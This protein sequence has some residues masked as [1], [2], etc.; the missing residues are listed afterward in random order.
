MN[1]LINYIINELENI[2]H[3][4]PWVGSTY[5][6]KLKTVSPDL[7]FKRPM[8]DMHSIAEIISHLTLWRKEAILKIKTGTGSKTDDCEENWLS[9]K[10]LKAKGWKHII[11]EYDKTLTEL[12]ALLRQE[13]D[14]FLTKEYYDTDFKVTYPYQFLLSGMLQHDIYHLGQLGLIIKYL[15][16]SH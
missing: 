15:N 12:I 4:Q 10:T 5:I 2:Q 13:N 8:E 1:N 14:S 16:K 11:S 6:S 7:V 9:N 3:G